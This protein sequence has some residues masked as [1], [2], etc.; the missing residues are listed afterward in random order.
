[1][2]IKAGLGSTSIV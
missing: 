2:T 1:M